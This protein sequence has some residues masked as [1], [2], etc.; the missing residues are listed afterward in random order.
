MQWH[1]FMPGMRVRTVEKHL[2]STGNARGKNIIFRGTVSHL[3]SYG[4]QVVWVRWD[5][6]CHAYREV[7]PIQPSLICREERR[8]ISL[9]QPVARI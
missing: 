1:E 6:A 2:R 4:P 5:R 8:E 3:S 7:Y 9:L